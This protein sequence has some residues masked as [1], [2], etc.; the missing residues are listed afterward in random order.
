MQINI[1]TES[2]IADSLQ[3]AGS[4]STIQKLR[5]LYFRIFKRYRRLEV[6]RC[7]YA[8]ANKLICDTE[9]SPE[10]ERWELAAEENH[11]PIIGIVWLERRERIVM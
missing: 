3:R 4:T 2:A 6:R 11:N 10:P 7:T 5:R 1:Q 9:R 8:E